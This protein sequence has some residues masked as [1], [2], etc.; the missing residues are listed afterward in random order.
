[1]ASENGAAPTIFDTLG[2]TPAEVGI[3]S[4]FWVT[5]YFLSSFISL[6]AIFS[7][8]SAA[9]PD[10]RPMSCFSV[11]M[12]LPAPC[13]AGFPP[14]AI[15]IST[16]SAVTEALPVIGSI[17]GLLGMLVALFMYREKVGKSLVFIIRKVTRSKGR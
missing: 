16:V 9:N 3:C 10:L 13:R 17:L 7:M 6:E 8:R 2:M 1:M 11:F 15:L 14:I 4:A 5:M 12:P